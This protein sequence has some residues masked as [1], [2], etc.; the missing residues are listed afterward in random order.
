MLV[1]KD[2]SQLLKFLYQD[3]FYGLFNH[4]FF[5]RKI[6][7]IILISILGALYLSYFYVNMR[8]LAILSNFSNA[9]PA[10]IAVASKITL[11]SF[12]DVTIVLSVVIFMVINST[13]GLSKN[14]IYFV[15]TLPFKR[16]EVLISYKIFKLSIGATLFSILI[17][18]VTPALKLVT[19][20]YMIALTILLSLYLV[21]GAI[22][23]I[24]NNL[25]S[26]I[27]VNIFHNNRL[28]ILILNLCILL[29]TIFYF[30]VGRYKVEYFIG[31]SI[32]T[33]PL[34]VITSV[35]SSIILWVV[36]FISMNRLD[37]HTLFTIKKDFLGFPVKPLKAS[38]LTMP[39]FA[40]FR[41]K[42]FLYFSLIF[43]LL[44]ALTVIFQNKQNELQLLI[45]M[46]PLF[47]VP[48]MS[49]A[50]ATLD[51]RK[52]I[53]S[54]NV[55]SINELQGI[56]LITFIISI[57]SLIIG[58][59]SNQKLILFFLT[60]NIALSGIIIGFLF[61]KS[62]GNIN[63][64]VSSVL[65]IIVIILLLLSLNI[66]WALFPICCFLIIC[67]YIILKKETGPLYELR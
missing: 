60:I 67:L 21:F 52:M 3:A 2:I 51:F 63:D 24:I 1:L 12:Y 58:L 25:Y 41:N 64:T 16:K 32:A 56:V 13:G 22:F 39:I 19:S 59:A 26:F 54:F 34:I 55:K 62:Q 40:T 8:Q 20:S 36:G 57:P 23:L 7:V 31:N 17:I 30:L 47:G 38:T 48:L 18:I 42:K 33:K 44:V 5:K 11:I 61:P 28:G 27:K 49:Y 53:T 45:Y 14:S 43:V 35:L 37:I 66:Q 9:T 10:E 50:D 65:L 15:A 29:I 46:S 6:N 4:P